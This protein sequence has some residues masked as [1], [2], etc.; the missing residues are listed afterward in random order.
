MTSGGF[1]ACSRG[2]LH[3]DYEF[4]I[5]IIDCNN[6]YN[7]RL[8]GYF[9]SNS[10][11]YNY[12]IV[13]KDDFVF[14]GTLESLEVFDCSEALSIP[15]ITLP[16]PSAFRLAPPFPNPFNSTVTISYSVRQASLPVRLAVYDISGRLVTDLTA[17]DPP[18]SAGEH[19]VVWDASSVGAGVY[20]VK[21]LAFDQIAIEKIV[22]TR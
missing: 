17:A 3:Q 1:I 9:R 18:R 13:M 2:R 11:G 8:S 21:L 12:G 20:F 16:T 7:L 14:M 22:L 6:P 5:G 19:K 10:W 4:A 15:D